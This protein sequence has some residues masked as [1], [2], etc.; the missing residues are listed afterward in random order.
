MYINFSNY[1]LIV[2]SSVF[3]DCFIREYLASNYTNKIYKTLF[4]LWQQNCKINIVKAKVG[5]NL[6]EFASVCIVPSYD[7]R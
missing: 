6:V 4:P 7:G 5:I 2:K 3:N 1:A